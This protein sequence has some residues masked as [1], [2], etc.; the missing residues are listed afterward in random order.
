MVPR[1]LCK[2]ESTF[3]VLLKISWLQRLE[4]KNGEDLLQTL[5]YK[6]PLMF[7]KRKTGLK[8]T[9]SIVGQEAEL[10]KICF[11][12][13]DVNGYSFSQPR[14]KTLYVVIISSP[15]PQQHTNN[16]LHASSLSISCKFGLPGNVT[17]YV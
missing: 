14:R 11:M 9:M 15:P 2:S 8:E 13:K 16:V 10:D 7:A 5:K 12:G 6:T 4:I 17:R 1:V 3:S